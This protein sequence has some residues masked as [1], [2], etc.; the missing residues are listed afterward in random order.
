MGPRR[1]PY[2]NAPSVTFLPSDLCVYPIGGAVVLPRTSVLYVSAAPLELFKRLSTYTW[3]FQVVQC[4]LGDLEKVDEE[5]SVCPSLF[6]D[7]AAVCW[8]QM[9]HTSTGN[10]SVT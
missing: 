10:K 9:E 1:S 3:A 7:S 8:V 4:Y 6:S 2:V 5:C